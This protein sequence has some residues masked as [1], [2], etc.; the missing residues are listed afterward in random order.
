MTSHA[1][2]GSKVGH[3]VV[4]HA[5]L[6]NALLALSVNIE[7][8]SSSA[9]VTSVKSAKGLGLTQ[10]QR[11]GPIDQSPGSGAPGSDKKTQFQGQG[12]TSHPESSQCV[13]GRKGERG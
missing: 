4:L 9:R 6:W 5:L 3:Q 8:V 10:F 2:I 11:L 1:F 7:F 13:F 12:E